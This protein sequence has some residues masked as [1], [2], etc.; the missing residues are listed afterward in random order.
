MNASPPAA[1]FDALDP[2]LVVESVEE[3]FGLR[4]DGYWFSYP[5]YVNRVYG[6]RDEDGLEYVVKFYRP[7]RWDEATIREEH[8][9]IFQLA[10]AEV[11]VASPICDGE[12]ESLQALVLEDDD[13]RETIYPFGL[14]PKRGGRTFDA[15]NDGDWRRLG[16]LAGRIHAV[17]RLEAALSR[18]VFEPGVLDTYAR[19]LLD[20]GLVYPDCAHDFQDACA[21][22]SAILD[23]VLGGAQRM[24]IHGDF[25]RGNILDRGGE[26]LLVI[27]LDDMAMGPAVQDLW[28]LLPGHARE[29]GRQFELILEGYEEFS[30]FN[31]AEL[32]LIEPLRVLRMVRFLAWQAR[33]RS[34]AGF[35]RAFPDWGSKSFWIKELEDLRDQL[36][37]LEP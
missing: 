2:G 12:G 32:S 19:E 36:G 29:C 6:L 25:H 5:S 3:A 30:D 14:F 8:R 21:A 20:P 7:G 37:E 11:P 18:P 28:L 17:G 34:D 26:G 27:D 23:P 4:L 16:S 31:R 13:G 24:R 33:Q 10:A 9:F 22:A 35:S 15:D 1:P